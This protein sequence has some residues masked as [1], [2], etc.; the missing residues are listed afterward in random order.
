MA[1]QQVISNW[2]ATRFFEP[3]GRFFEFMDQYKG[4]FIC[5]CGS[6]SGF[7]PH[8]LRVW[9]HDADGID[10]YSR[11]DGYQ[12]TIK[13][14]TEREWRPTDFVLVC[15]PSHGGWAT[16][17]I[18]NAIEAGAMVG[19][20]G[21]ARNLYTDLTQEQIDSVD[22]VVTDLGGDG[23]FMYCWGTGFDGARIPSSAVSPALDE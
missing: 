12:V 1:S 11:A 6:G 21:L 19:Y 16:E 2:P 17:V 3:N 15:R 4:K 10:L 20:V 23:E 7:V 9:G 5:D 14:A 22:L 8:A 18:Q 13:D